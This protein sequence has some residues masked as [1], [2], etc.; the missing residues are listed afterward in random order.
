MTLRLTDVAQQV[1]S[2][3]QTAFMKN[4]YIM[5][6]VVVL[7]ETLNEMHRKKIVLC[8]DQNRF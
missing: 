5:E 7:H 8:D 3:E 2:A 1:I 4:R 6:G